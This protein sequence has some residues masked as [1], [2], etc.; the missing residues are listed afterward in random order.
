MQTDMQKIF[1]E[2]VAHHKE[3]NLPLAELLYKRCLAAYPDHPQTLCQ[4]GFLT[5]QQ[6]DPVRGESLIRDALA[7]DR[8]VAACFNAL[9]HVLRLQSRDG[10]ALA[11]FDQ[12]V[13][14][15]PDYAEA[16][17]NLGAVAMALGLKERAVAAWDVA[18]KLVPSNV[19]LACD[20]ASLLESMG[21]FGAAAALYDQ[22]LT[23]EP[24]DPV[25]LFS[26]FL[27]HCAMRDARE[28]G[29]LAEPY[30][31]DARL[32]KPCLFDMAVRQAIGAWLCGLDPSVQAA[33]TLAD[34]WMGPADQ[35]DPRGQHMAACAS[36]LRALMAQGPRAEAPKESRRLAVIGD[37]HVLGYDG[38]IAATNGSV[39]NAFAH[40]VLGGMAWH[41][42]NE[43]DNAVKA[44]VRTVC[45]RL[46]EGPRLFV[47]G[48]IDCRHEEGL[49]PHVAHTGAG[50]SQSVWE[51]VTGYIGFLRGLAGGRKDVGVALVPAPNESLLREKGGLTTRQ[52]A[53]VDD[54]VR[55]FN[56]VLRSEA[57]KA[58]FFVLDTF[59]LT[60]KDGSGHAD[61]R[62]VRPEILRTLLAQTP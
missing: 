4:L 14:L 28:W 27:L 45:E 52:L 58:G 44:Q 55:Q 17:Q 31:K 1:E 7:Q 60:Q 2:A 6:G 62:H 56:T 9:G 47:F 53:A 43:E 54:V 5:A 21:R 39:V 3:G 13:A 41:L 10:E 12:A 36:Y 59:A 49:L 25:L 33:L 38:L 37:S 57:P 40:P 30:V 20:L 50:L 26:R 32:P 35:L 42:A 16:L 48:E 24:E 22:A 61:I 23:L 15:K 8:Y 11:A 29:S 18:L 46:G 51:T 34:R 19:N